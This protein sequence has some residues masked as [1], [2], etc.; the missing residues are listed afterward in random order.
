MSECCLKRWPKSHQAAHKNRLDNVNHCLRAFGVDGGSTR[1]LEDQ[2]QAS[3]S[4]EN[5]IRSSLKRFMVIGEG[6][7]GVIDVPTYRQRLQW[8]RKRALTDENFVEE[9]VFAGLSSPHESRNGIRL[10]SGRG[11]EIEAMYTEIAATSGNGAN[12]LL[13]VLDPAG[14][15]LFGNP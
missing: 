8:L 6:P 12:V 3:K 5:L 9:I 14:R 13:L 11:N 10:W 2:R 1:A 7:I 15:P 4:G